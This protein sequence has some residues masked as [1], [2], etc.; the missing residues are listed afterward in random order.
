M[1]DVATGVL[2]RRVL[3]REKTQTTPGLLQL[4]LHRGGTGLRKSGASAPRITL[5]NAGFSPGAPT[6]F[7]V[8]LLVCGSYPAT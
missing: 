4:L 6:I 5:T 8:N 3:R 7:P 1:T 2:A